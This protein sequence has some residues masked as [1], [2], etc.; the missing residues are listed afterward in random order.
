V[1]AATLKD[2]TPSGVKCFLGFGKNLFGFDE[3][4]IVDGFLFVGVRIRL[5][6]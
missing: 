5:N 4:V 3:S 1:H 2:F 6:K